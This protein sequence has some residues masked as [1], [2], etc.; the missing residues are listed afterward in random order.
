M[1]DPDSHPGSII[2]ELGTPKSTRARWLPPDPAPLHPRPFASLPRALVILLAGGALPSLL[3]GLGGT[4]ANGMAAW[5][6]G[7]NAP[8]L[9]P[10]V[11][12]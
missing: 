8:Q 7:A 9:L 4:T 1:R 5:N 3:P 2:G 11:G 6:A 10:H 12:P